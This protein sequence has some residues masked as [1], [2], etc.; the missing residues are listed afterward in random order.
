MLPNAQ[1][2]RSCRSSLYVDGVDNHGADFLFSS[3]MIEWLAPAA[4]EIVP[5][6]DDDSH[7]KKNDGLKHVETTYWYQCTRYCMCNKKQLRWVAMDAYPL[8]LKHGNGRSTI[9]D[10]PTQSMAISG[11]MW[12][13][14]PHKIWPYMVQYL[15]FR[16]LRFPLNLLRGF[17]SQPCLIPPGDS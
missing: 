12:G 2:S 8:V 5:V 9:D 3:T 11:S 10:L 4:S 14:C 17:S 16:I 6:G 13:L 1:T 7:W 15:H